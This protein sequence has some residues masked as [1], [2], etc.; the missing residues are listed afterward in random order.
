[1]PPEL[2]PSSPQRR[3]LLAGAAM[4][5]VTGAAGAAT[6]ASEGIVLTVIVPAGQGTLARVQRDFDLA[7]LAAL[8]QHTIRTKLP[9]YAQARHFTGPMLRDIVAAVGGAGERLVVQALLGGYRAEIPLND[10]RR[11]PVIVAYQVDGRAVGVRDKGPLMIVYPF[12]DDPELRQTRYLG[13][14]VWNLR[15]IE[16]R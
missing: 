2:L 12:D 5:L 8:P 3:L 10:L 9:W 13:R 16:L 6:R 11:W 7:A 4:A 14:A 1:M 15:T